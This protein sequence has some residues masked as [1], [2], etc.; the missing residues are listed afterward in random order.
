MPFT[1]IKTGKNKGKYKSPSG[2]IWTKDQV[3]RYYANNKED[4][5]EEQVIENVKFTFNPTVFEAK[6]SD[7]DKNWL[8]IGGTALV[9]GV[10]ENKNHYTIE[11]L[12]ENDG[13]E[14]KWLV[15]HPREA[16][17][18]VVGKGKLT[19]EEGKLVHE[20][21]IRNTSNHPDIVEQVADGFL[22]PSIHAS[23]KKVKRKKDEY[24]VEGLSIDGVGLVAFQGVKSASID[25]ALA[26]S[27]D[28]K[29][30]EMNESQDGDEKNN[31]DKGDNK[32]A[33]EE[34]KKD[35][36]APAPEAEKKPVE[37]VE[38]LKESNKKLEDELKALKEAKKSEI[39]ESILS[40]NSELKKEELMKES[41]DKLEMIKQY[42]Q[43]LVE[44]KETTNNAIVESE[45][46]DDEEDEESAKEPELKEYAENK[47]GV[48]FT[49]EAY[50]KFN[51]EII[52]RVR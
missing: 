34:P 46:D 13:K 33:D 42:E 18:H 2:K 39:V 23:A 45:G 30:N 9:E 27:F 40:L 48:S 26:E 4:K 22:G 50:D 17:S 29:W 8:N 6:K 52:E 21:K 32:M 19:L 3:K 5:M 25:Y 36:P 47:S 51:K 31:N 14:F 15:G 49:K 20:G 1:L 38:A 12:K 24:Y 10:S 35:V 41:E 43:K 7:K 44:N 37:D 11:N 28:K 16:E